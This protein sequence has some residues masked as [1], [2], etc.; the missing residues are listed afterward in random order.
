MSD[1]TKIPARELKPGDRLKFKDPQNP[2]RFITRELIE[3]ID[4]DGE[5]VLHVRSGR[6][7]M[8]IPVAP[9]RDVTIAPRAGEKRYVLA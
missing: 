7:R 8:R 3:V 1:D 4:G 9:N 6:G 2:S 5:L